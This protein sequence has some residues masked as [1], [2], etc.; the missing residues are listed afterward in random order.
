[1]IVVQAHSLQFGLLTTVAI[2]LHEIPHEISDFAILLRADFD[3][4]SAIKAQVWHRLSV[5][6]LIEFSFQ[7]LTSAGGLMG[8]IVALTANVTTTHGCTHILAFTAGGFIN[9][10][11]VQVLPELLHGDGLTRRLVIIDSKTHIKIYLQ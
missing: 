4:W 11:L 5:R 3:R 10:A 8:A 1:M 9:I 2:L 7:L 6:V